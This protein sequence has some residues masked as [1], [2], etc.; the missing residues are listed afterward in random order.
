MRTLL[1]LLFPLSTLSQI[2]TDG[3]MSW[4][5]NPY[6]K[7]MCFG[8]QPLAGCN[9]CLG[10]AT[11]PYSITLTEP[12]EVTFTV[13]SVMLKYNAPYQGQYLLPQH[14][15]WMSQQH[16]NVPPVF[17]LYENGAIIGESDCWGDYDYLELKDTA[18]NTWEFFDNEPVNVTF[19]PNFTLVKTLPAGYYVFRI[20]PFSDCQG[21]CAWGWLQWRVN[22]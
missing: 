9:P 14:E 19:N 4:M 6:P 11:T 22:Y 18:G 20:S 8:Q 13:E 17:I 1:L 21:G 5:W 2:P 16:G 3:T 7:G 12:T 10:W 15:M